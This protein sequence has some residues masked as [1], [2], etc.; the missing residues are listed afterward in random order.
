LCIKSRKYASLIIG[1]KQ[2]GMSLWIKKR[3][4]FVATGSAIYGFHVH[5]FQIIVTKLIIE[6]PKRR[7]IGLELIIAGYGCRVDNW[8][9]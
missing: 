4:L 6:I 7:T 9:K 1:T 2:R 5:R 8:P 3:F